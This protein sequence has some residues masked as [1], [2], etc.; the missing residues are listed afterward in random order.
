MTWFSSKNVYRKSHV[1]SYLRTDTAI[2][3]KQD[4]WRASL[5]VRNLFGVDY[6]ESSFNRNRLFAGED[7]TIQGTIS[8]QF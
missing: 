5:N 8:W 3:Y 6:F 2:F 7:L 1:P 4:K